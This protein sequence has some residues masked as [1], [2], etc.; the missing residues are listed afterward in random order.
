M[1]CFPLYDTLIAKNIP[2][3]D[4]S[5]RQKEE[6]ISKISTTDMKGKQITF[7]L[8]C[9]HYMKDMEDKKMEYLPYNCSWSSPDNYS[10]NFADFPIPLRHI[11]YR[12][13]IMHT[14][15]SA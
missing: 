14:N 6:F 13:I 15:V 4:L 7:S 11:L 3:K 10:W 5:M 2:K 12:Y 9:V 8:I 1:N